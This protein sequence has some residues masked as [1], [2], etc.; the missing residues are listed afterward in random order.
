MR[1]RLN[2][3]L[4]AAK[5]IN[6]PP[7]FD[8]PNWEDFKELMRTYLDAPFFLSA[9]C[10]PKKELA[11]REIATIA[12]KQDFELSRR[13]KANNRVHQFSLVLINYFAG[14]SKLTRVCCD[15]FARKIPEVSAI[16]P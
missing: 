5:G 8:L 15:A 10:L 6:E 7:S 9:A 11:F 12:A 4:K 2:V 3:S 13:L 1:H 14:L 16:A